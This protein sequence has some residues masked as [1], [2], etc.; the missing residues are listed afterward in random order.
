VTEPYDP[1]TPRQI[2]RKKREAART[3]EAMADSVEL[4]AEMLADGLIS[5]EGHAETMAIAEAVAEKFGGKAKT[6]STVEGNSASQLRAFI[7]RVEFIQG[8]IDELNKD[9]SDIFGEAKGTGFDTKAMK[10]IIRDRKRTKEERQ[11]EEA[12]YQSYLA[13]LG[14]E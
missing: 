2:A 14:M 6:E 12:I 11:E 10:R 9:K 7:E 5:A 1:Y 8:E 4:S 13:A 3:V